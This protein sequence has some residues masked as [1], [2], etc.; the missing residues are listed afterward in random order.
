MVAGYW[1]GG[2]PQLDEAA[3]GGAH[4]G[5][6]GWKL[7]EICFPP[8]SQPNYL[9]SL[10]I[11]N[12]IGG[13]CI[14]RAHRRLLPP[15]LSGSTLVP[16]QGLLKVPLPPVLT[17]RHGLAHPCTL[18]VSDSPGH[19]RKP[20]VACL[21]CLVECLESHPCLVRLSGL[22]LCPSSIEA[23]IR[24]T[25]PVTGLRPV[26]RPTGPLLE[27]PTG[28][29]VGLT[30]S[31]PWALP[32]RPTVLHASWSRRSLVLDRPCSAHC[33]PGSLEPC[34]GTSPG[35]WGIFSNPRY[36][37]AWDRGMYCILCVCKWP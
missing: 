22:F 15:A 34:S 24:P 5:V 6:R 10:A 36:I 28:Q 17:L 8:G 4:P 29:L 14:P 37:R 25:A 32:S 27:L 21:E 2:F 23:L 12:F 9:S 3:S 33:C 26:P 7:P 18:P 13:P 1:V 11:T 20:S 31:R 30:P 35:L 16:A 19:D